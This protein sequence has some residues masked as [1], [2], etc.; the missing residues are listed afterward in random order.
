MPEVWPP[1]PLRWDPCRLTDGTVV[2]D[3]ITRADVPAIVAGI[4]T[5]IVRWLPLPE[6]YTEADAIAF[7]QWQQEMAERGVSLTFAVRTGAGKPLIGV[8]S[9]NFRSAPGVTNV[10]YWMAAPA[11]GQGLAAR[12]TRLLAAHAFRRFDVRRVEVL[13]QLDNAA[14]RRAAERA[15]A[16]FEGIR[17]NG[18]EQRGEPLDAAVYSLVPGDVQEEGQDPAYL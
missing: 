17:R 8:A 1:R 15:G 18:I 5:E 16:V 2:L 13:V 10:G 9:L 3:G 12:A 6:P 4:D 14:S 11:R 7:V